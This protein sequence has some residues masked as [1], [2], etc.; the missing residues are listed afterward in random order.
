TTNREKDFMRIDSEEIRFWVRKLDSIPS[1]KMTEDFYDRLKAEVPKFLRYLVDSIDVEYETG[2][3]QVELLMPPL[4]RGNRQ[5]AVQQLL[6]GTDI[7]PAVRLAIEHHERLHAEAGLHRLQR[8][9]L[10]HQRLLT[11]AIQAEQRPIRLFATEA[12]RQRPPWQIL[13]QR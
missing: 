8:T 1:D 6:A 2:H 10:A 3:L 12:A 13:G 5:I 11:A 9:V 4:H 7:G